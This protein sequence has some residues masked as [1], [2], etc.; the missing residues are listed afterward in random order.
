MKKFLIASIICLLSSACLAMATG[1]DMAHATMGCMGAS[2]VLGFVQLPSGVLQAVVLQQMWE[3]ALIEPFRALGEFLTGIPR[4]DQYVGNNVINLAQIGAD[5]AVLINN[6]TYPINTAA[7]T[8]DNNALAL[9]KY[10]TENTV[11]T[12]DE[13]YAL[14]Y[15]KPGS[16]VRQHRDA[17]TEKMADHA[18]HGLCVSADSATTPVLQ[19][20]G[21]NDG[22]GRARLTAQDLINLQ[23]KLDNLKVPT[24]GRRLVLCPE[25]CGDL[26][27]ADLSFAQR[28]HNATE[29]LI[30]PN[31][32]G[33]ET[34]KYPTAPVFNAAG[35]KKAFGAAGAAL[36]RKASVVFIVQRSFTA[37]G[38][39]KFYFE[40]SSI[41]PKTR[42]SVA[43]YRV[44]GATLPMKSTGFAAVISANV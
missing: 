32:Y 12:D 4:K 24:R 38:T 3:T 42:E 36:D 29:G 5:P 22:T 37:M 7:R 43:G 13:L 26:L 40:D 11:I 28:F 25:H 16:V 27:I 30:A 9:F 33:F 44:Y 6:T 17:L 41:S 15:D 31:Y 19:T 10:D 2:M 23:V 18:I 35:T 39:L 20:T 21:A 1:I 34:Y 14:P 8:D